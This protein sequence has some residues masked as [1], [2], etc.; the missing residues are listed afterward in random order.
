MDRD[1]FEWLSKNFPDAKIVRRYGC[2]S[3]LDGRKDPYRRAMRPDGRLPLST[4]AWHRSAE[5]EAGTN[6]AWAQHQIDMRSA[7]ACHRPFV[8]G[9]PHQKLSVTQDVTREAL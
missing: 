6:E 1:S 7:R 5:P 2:G 9:S 8:T 3:D 4:A